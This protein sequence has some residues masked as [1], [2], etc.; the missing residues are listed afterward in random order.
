[1]PT[2]KEYL[3]EALYRRGV[4]HV[5]GVPAD[6]VLECFQYLE[7]SSRV[8][9]LRMND[10]PH[11]GAAAD[12]YARLRGL[13][14]VLV[15]YGAGGFKVMN[16]TAQACV[17]DSPVLVV[18][19]APAQDEYL[20]GR[21][22]LHYRIH[23][24]V[25]GRD[26]QRRA[27]SH[28]T[29]M[30]RRIDSVYTAR[31]YIDSLIEYIVAEKQPGYLEVPRNLWGAELPE[32]DRTDR[33]VYIPPVSDKLALAAGLEQA[34]SAIRNSE[35]PVFWVGT[36]VQRYELQEK[37]LEMATAF[38]IPV[39]TTLFGKSAIDE[40]HP[41][42]TG[43]YVGVQS[44][45]HRYDDD[46][47]RDYVET[48]DCMIMLGVNFSDFNFGI[49][50]VQI[51]RKAR[52]IN[53]QK[54][55]LRIDSALYEEV[56]LDAFVTG[57]AD[58]DLGEHT[59]VEPPPETPFQM[60][61]SDTPLNSDIFFAILNHH[62]RDNT[63]IVSDIG[64]CLF[65]A[66]KL[67]TGFERFMSPGVYGSM[68]WSVSAALGVKFADNSLRPYVIV[69]DGAFVMGQE[70]AIAKLSELNLDPVVFILNNRGYATL[71][72][73]VTGEFN[74]VPG[75]RYEKICEAYGGRGFGVGT[76][77]ELDEALEEIHRISGTPCIVN[78]TLPVLD[79][80]TALQRIS[81]ELT[82]GVTRGKKS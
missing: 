65:G 42:Y 37:V 48:S 62:I 82:R 71:H 26:D 33:Y 31:A 2:V 14:V 66:G 52:L 57:L 22:L 5:F 53:A 34:V 44:A 24:V 15:T 12:A 55:E 8:K 40:N 9:A 80:T 28:V 61:S 76:A 43:L 79:K 59:F 18:S 78:V 4:E 68:G 73:M 49:G 29:G 64:D 41:M 67:D 54:R 6:F 51:D 25:K 11:A 45:S 7:S 27:F 23:H 70:S 56:L 77:G 21:S 13:G 16:S 47:V 17:E 50:T 19:G 20:K 36:D 69:G 63:I 75:Y 39:C 60:P 32:D 38:N 74:S 30:N 35:K 46:A 81:T 3:A 1:M 58:A 10:E 72:T